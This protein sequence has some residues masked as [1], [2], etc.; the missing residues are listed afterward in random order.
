MYAYIDAYYLEVVIEHCRSLTIG[1]W[2][3]QDI[4]LR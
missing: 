4:L 1:P 2:E 3:Y